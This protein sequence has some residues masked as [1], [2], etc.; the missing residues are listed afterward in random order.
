MPGIECKSIYFIDTVFF[1]I[2][3]GFR[4]LDI[5]DLNAFAQ[6]CKFVFS[7]RDKFLAHV[8]LIASCKDCPHDCRIIEFLGIVY[9]VSSGNT[10]CVDMSDELMIFSEGINHIAFH[11]LH[12]EYIVEKFESF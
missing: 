8:S 3:K 7:C 10:T 12:V 1:K 4:E 2:Q 9:F 5:T 6:R 11:D